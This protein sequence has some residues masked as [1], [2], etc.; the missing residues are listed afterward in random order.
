MDTPEEYKKCSEINK[1]LDE[2]YEMLYTVYYNSKKEE[3]LKNK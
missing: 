2:C 1:Q 3:V